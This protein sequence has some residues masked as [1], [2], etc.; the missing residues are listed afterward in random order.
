[1]DINS[2]SP[3]AGQQVTL[4]QFAG[5]YV[6]ALMGAG[7]CASCRAQAA[8]LEA[9][10]ADLKKQGRT[11]VALLVIN[12][13]SASSPSNKQTMSTCSLSVCP[14]VGAA[15]SFP[16]LQGTSMFG[17]QS[18][19]DTKTGQSGKKNDCFIYAPNGSLK[20]KH[21]GKA[22]VNLTQFDKEVRSN[23]SL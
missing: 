15:L 6:V 14:T 1:M 5:K 19:M 21:V 22:T 11:D 17:W 10:H 20:F 4:S 12:D 3:T 2:G 9:I 13:K 23:I 8:F 16:V 7:W 18:F